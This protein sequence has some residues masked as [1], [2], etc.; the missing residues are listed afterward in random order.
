V[1]GVEVGLMTH[2]P[3]CNA[4]CVGDEHYLL[5]DC[6]GCGDTISVRYLPYGTCRNCYGTTDDPNHGTAS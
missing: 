5:P 6:P 1:P 2:Y 3:E 4:L